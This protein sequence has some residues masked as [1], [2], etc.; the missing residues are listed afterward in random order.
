MTTYKDAGVDV[1]AGDLAVKRISF[2]AK[3]T[4]N[5]NTLSDIGSFGGCWIDCDG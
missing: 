1:K 3:S 4:F 5:A 2:L